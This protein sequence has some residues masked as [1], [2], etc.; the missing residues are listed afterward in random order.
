M[1]IIP[2]PGMMSEVNI[3]GNIFSQAQIPLDD[4]VV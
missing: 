4:R 3:G 2:Q 1:G